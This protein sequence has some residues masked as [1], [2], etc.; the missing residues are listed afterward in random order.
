MAHEMNKQFEHRG[1]RF[2]ICVQL[3]TTVERCPDGK[4]FHTVICNDMGI[5]N[6]YH[7]KEVE[8][9][10]LLMHITFAIEAAKKFVDEREDGVPPLDQRLADLGFV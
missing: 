2:N 6:Y 8:D 10:N 1:Y 5:T 4:R 7:K 3:N 9:A